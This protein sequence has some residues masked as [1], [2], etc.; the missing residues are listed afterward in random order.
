MADEVN[1]LVFGH[2]QSGKSSIISRILELGGH[3]NNEQI[4]SYKD[5]SKV[6]GQIEEKPDWY[7]TYVKAA[8]SHKPI[9]ARIFYQN[10]GRKF[11][12]HEFQ[13][14]LPFDLCLYLS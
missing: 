6:A 12:L 4:K 8:K 3:L 7:L 14:I 10:E 11:L 5:K 1:V 13:V 2:P 9:F